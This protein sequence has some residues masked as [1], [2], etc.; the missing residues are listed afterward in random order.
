MTVWKKKPYA[1]LVFGAP[2][3]GKTFFAE[4]FSKT[5]CAPFL[6][7]SRLE[8]KF[9]SDRQLADELIKQVASS[10]VDMIIEGYLD[11]EEQRNEMRKMLEDLGYKPVLVWV[12]TDL[13]TIKQRIRHV[14]KDL[15]EAKGVLAESYKHIE[16]PSPAE[17]P[18][19]ISGKHTYRTQS[20][21]VVSRL[22]LKDVEL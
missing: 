3:S 20:Q 10:K 18:I 16:A 9:H 13:N 11:T 17:K 15:N 4:Q 22:G 2:M 19:V 21:N 1:I 7:I 5:I 14:H 12:Q 8:K 6:N